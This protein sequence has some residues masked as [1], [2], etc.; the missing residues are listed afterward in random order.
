MTTLDVKPAAAI[1][2]PRPPAGHRPRDATRRA[3]ARASAPRA[4]PPRRVPPLR[5]L[6]IQPLDLRRA[7]DRRRHRLSLS[8]HDPRPRRHHRLRQRCARSLLRRR[9]QIRSRNSGVHTVLQARQH[10]GK[11]SGQ[12]P[13]SGRIG[14]LTGLAAVGRVVIGCLVAEPCT[15]RRARRPPALLRPPPRSRRTSRRHRRRSPPSPRTYRWTS[16]P[17]SVPMRRRPPPRFRSRVWSRQP[18]HLP[19]Q[20]PL[21]PSLPRSPLRPNPP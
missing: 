2:A 20:P 14:R 19:R 7:R 4:A 9:Q 16:P 18:L 10:A 5:A 6:G 21:R 11:L 17:I 1:E 12:R 3:A 13:G 15:R 8:G